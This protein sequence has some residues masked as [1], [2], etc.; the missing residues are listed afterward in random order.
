MGR[1]IEVVAQQDNTFH[2]RGR[3]Q[4]WRTESDQSITV[5]VEAIK[6]DVRLERYGSYD[7]RFLLSPSQRST[8]SLNKEER[9]LKLPRRNG[10]RYKERRHQQSLF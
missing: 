2:I 9:W 7:D 10:D 1:K 6:A 4:D 5:H 3:R 8:V